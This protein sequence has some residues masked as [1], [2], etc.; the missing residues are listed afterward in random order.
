MV[1]LRPPPPR[2]LRVGRVYGAE[3]Q[4][5]EEARTRGRRAAAAAAAECQDL[6]PGVHGGGGGGGGTPG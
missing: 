5:E 1:V 2:P 3:V 6:V 4:A